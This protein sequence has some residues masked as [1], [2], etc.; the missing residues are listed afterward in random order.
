MAKFFGGK[1]PFDH[2]FFTQPF[3]GLFGGKNPFDDPFFTS[4]FDNN[5]G[6]RRQITIE[7][8]NPGDDGGHDDSWQKNKPSKELSVK[9]WDEYPTG[10][11]SF[12][13]QRVAYGGPDGLYYTSSMGK[14][15]GSD[16]VFLM[17][18]KEEDR[19]VG[20]S[21][22]TISKGILDKGHS[23]TKKQSSDGRVDSVQTLHNLNEDE[24]A[25]FEENWKTNA[26]KV[27][28][29][30]NNGFNLLENSGADKSIWDDFANWSGW[31]GWPFPSLEYYGNGGA[32]PDGESQGPS[33]RATS[34]KIIPL[35]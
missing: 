35:E 31:G 27:L 15:A 33:S 19:T 3:G 24:L 28:P 32:Q 34:R 1:D 12:S 11:Q 22:H 18:M 26:D 7:E 23:L 20:E 25:G 13:F 17:E 8:L 21:L 9:N 30:W 29:G 14:R 4:P 5:S 10:G 2:P 16:G 6:P